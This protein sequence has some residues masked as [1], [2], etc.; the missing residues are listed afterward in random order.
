MTIIVVD[1]ETEFGLLMRTTLQSEGFDVILAENGARALE[2]LKGAKID[3][4]ICDIYM[5]IMDGMKFHESFRKLPGHEKTPF[6]FISGYDDEHTRN[7]VKDPRFEGFLLKA[8]P[9]HLLMEWVRYLTTPEHL[10]P[11][12]RPGS[13]GPLV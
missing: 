6:L 3:L 10:R 1:D 13:S 7:S 2:K 9:K 5:P 12:L 11:S 4:V 8:S